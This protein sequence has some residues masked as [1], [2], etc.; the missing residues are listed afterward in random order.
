MLKKNIEKL[1]KMTSGFIEE[2]GY[3][4]VILYESL[5]W[6]VLGRFSRQQ[7]SLALIAEQAMKIGVAA[8]PIVSVLCFSVG[9][10]L[11]MQGLE[12]LKPYGAQSQVVTGIA[13]SVSR[14]FAALI[15]GI[16]VAGRS[17]SALAARIGS[18]KESQ[19]IDALQVIGID[20]VRYLVAPALV[21]MII[22]MPVLTI[23]GLLA[24]L[25]GAAIFTLYELS[26]PVAIYMSRSFEVMQAGDVLQG[27]SKSLVFAVLIVIVSVINGFQVRGGAEGVGL[28]T[29]R[30][31]VM[32]ISVIVVADMIFTFFLTHF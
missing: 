6:L 14:E 16:I 17:G 22:A 20:P 25:L 10:M 30:S 1:G 26:M 27:L 24:G 19:E 2:L 28:A 31:V 12:T 18:M 3:G 11:A 8:L 13:L 9:M 23:I 5:Y 4:T 29:T 7:V 32:S 15:T 21:A